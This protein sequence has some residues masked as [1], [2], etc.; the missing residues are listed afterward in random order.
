MRR[1]AC[2]IGCLALAGSASH[3]EDAAAAPRPLFDAPQAE[4]VALAGSEV[5]VASTTDHGG[6]RVTAVPLAGGPAVTRFFA[7]SPG[8]GWAATARVVSSDRLTALVVMYDDPEGNFRLS[9]VY[10]G[11]PSGPLTLVQRVRRPLRGTAW[12]PVDVD[13]HA[14][15]LLVQEARLS[16]L[17]FRYTVRSPGTAPVR[18]R[19]EPASSHTAIAGDLVAYLGLRGERPS[20]RLVDWRTG[21]VRNSI[22]LGEYSEDM[23][24]RDFDLMEDGQVVAVLDGRLVAA[25][26]GGT[27]RELPG[28]EGALEFSSPRFAGE[29]VAVLA[30]GPFDTLRPF[31]AD[32]AAGTRRPIGPPSTELASMDAGEGTVAWLANGCVIAMEA[33]DPSSPDPLPPGP[34]PRAEV[35]VEE[36]DQVVR[37]RAL[38]VVVTCVAAPAGCRGTAL[39]GRGGWAGRG[40]FR[41]AVGERESARIQVSRRGMRSILR[42]LRRCCPLD[43]ALG[44][45]VTDGRVG[46]GRGA[47]A[48]ITRVR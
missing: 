38:R 30:G 25:S 6:V 8:R 32:P 17:A 4:E 5:L 23:H 2:L 36:G 19:Q 3:V 7:R 35:L 44:A 43:L 14:D 28:A 42:Q 37:G 21:H 27:L 46:R 45:R 34:C 20:F 9:R 31:I 10:A 18:R 24:D 12:I 41:V 13:V 40:G 15:G 29:R 47:G 26:P 16:D 22:A 39:L 33:D 48:L 1:V 11:P